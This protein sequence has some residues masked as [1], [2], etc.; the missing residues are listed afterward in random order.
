[1]EE[2][3]TSSEVSEE[4]DRSQH[5]ILIESFAPFHFRFLFIKSENTHIVFET[6]A[7]ISFSLGAIQQISLMTLKWYPSVKNT[8]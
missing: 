2:A 1:M 8:H 5:K 6:D 3:T 7:V 4:E